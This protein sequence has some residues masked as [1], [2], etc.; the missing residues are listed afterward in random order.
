MTATSTPA[1]SKVM[2]AVCRSVCGVTWVH[3]PG[4]ASLAGDG[5]VTVDEIADG[6]GVERTATAGGEHGLIADVAELGH[7][8]GSTSTVWRLSGVQRCLRPL[9]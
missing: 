5:D 8:G 1:A 3:G 6:V 9:P 7:P 2:A 4:L